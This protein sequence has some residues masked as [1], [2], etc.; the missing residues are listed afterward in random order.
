MVLNLLLLQQERNLMQGLP[1]LVRMITG[2][3]F[4]LAKQH[5]PIVVGLPRL[6][7]PIPQFAFQKRKFRNG[8]SICSGKLEGLDSKCFGMN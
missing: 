3:Q 2:M 1:L 7:F 4:G 6:K 5:L 8:T